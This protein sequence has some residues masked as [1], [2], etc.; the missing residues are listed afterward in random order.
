MFGFQFDQLNCWSYYLQETLNPARGQSSTTLF[1]FI[2]L[3]HTC[4]NLMQIVD[5]GITQ[6][7]V[8]CKCTDTC[9]A[10][11]PL[12]PGIKKPKKKILCG[13]KHSITASVF[14]LNSLL[15]LFGFLFSEW[16]TRAQIQL[17]HSFLKT[18]L[19]HLDE[20]MP[21]RILGSEI[22]PSWSPM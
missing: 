22:V 21:N 19:T 11:R 10:N 5:F 16:N 6:G 13:K 15:L 20:T 8:G 7:V 9:V 2:F 14:K 1:S 17:G 3:L 12:L 18:G 4:D